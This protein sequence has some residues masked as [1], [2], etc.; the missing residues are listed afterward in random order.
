MKKLLFLMVAGI[1]GTMLIR[2]GHITITPDNQ[3][4]V[5]GYTVPIPDSVQKS[6]VMGMV[7][8]MMMGQLQIPAQS[9]GAPQ[10]PALPSVTSAAG[11][12]NPNVRPS[13]AASAPGSDGLNAAAKALR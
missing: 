10:R 9:T 3:I 13:S 11:T 12:Y 5:A 1:G 6:P 7:T 4:R 2:G 8:T